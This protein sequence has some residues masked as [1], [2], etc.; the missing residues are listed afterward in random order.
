M[1][2]QHVSRRSPALQDEGGLNV[3][4]RMMKSKD[5]QMNVEH[6]TSN[7][8]HRMKELITN[9]VTNIKNA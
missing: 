5:E 7:V 6:R 8:E 9:I 1:N 3:Q 2:V 4:R